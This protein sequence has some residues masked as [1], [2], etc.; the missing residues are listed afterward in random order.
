[1]FERLFKK[2]DV[3][4]KVED[5]PAYL[6][7]EFSAQK[8]EL[9]VKL[10]SYSHEILDL[11]L[12]IES[13]INSL[14]AQ[15]SKDKYANTVKNRFCTSVV[16][17]IAKAKSFSGDGRAFVKLAG[18]TVADIGSF[19]LRDFR[20]LHAFKDDMSKVAEKIK[21]LN[22]RIGYANKAIASAEAAKLD[23]IVERVNRIAADRSSISDIE[24]S[25]KRVSE[26]ESTLNASISELQQKAAALGEDFARHAEGRLKI[27]DVEREQHDIKSRI[28]NE[29][30]GLGRIF[31]K[32]LYYGDL[33]KDESHVLGEY[34]KDPGSAFLSDAEML[35]FSI[36]D[37]LYAYKD[38]KT[39]EMDEGRHEKVKDIMRHRK[40]LEELRLRHF[41]LEA[42]KSSVESEVESRTAPIVKDIAAA[43]AAAA[44]KQR[45]LNLLRSKTQRMQAEKQALEKEI[46]SLTASLESDL[47]QLLGRTARIIK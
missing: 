37:K 9:D 44:E 11:F 27:R 41:Q 20:H 24:Q 21:L 16:N 25:L 4:L 13:V 38:R 2:Q 29:F 31:K 28:G 47:S 10:K 22:A 39:I 33:T 19:N 26:F 5:V 30:S 36:V 17:Y 3:E 12:Q 42:D 18:E 35:I 43:K 32:F 46:T 45:E 23:R 6:D 40:I 15:E 34:I 7:R 8:A 1:M 14:S